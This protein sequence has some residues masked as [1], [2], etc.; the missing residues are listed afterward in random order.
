MKKIFFALIA[1]FYPVF[2]F[3]ADADFNDSTFETELEPGFETESSAEEN[4][5]S[6]PD[7]ENQFADELDSDIEPLKSKEKMR[8]DIPK[9]V[10]EIGFDTNVGISNN[11]FAV[12]DILKKEL[13]IDLRKIAAEID[14]KGLSFDMVLSSDFFM[15]LNLRNGV[16]VGVSSGLE[17]S[18]N[19]VISKEFF[20][21]LG[22]GNELNEKISVDGSVNSDVF[23]YAKTDVSFDIKSF[24]VNFGP[25]LFL[26]LLHLETTKFDSHF[27][28]KSDG[29]VDARVIAAYKINSCMPL[30]PLFDKDFKNFFKLNNFDCTMGFDLSS[31][32]EHQILNTL[33][34]RA[35]IRLPIVPGSM[36]NTVSSTL[37]MSYSADDIFDMIKNEGDKLNFDSGEKNYGTEKYWI[38]RPFRTGGEIAW[39]PFGK[40]IKFGALLG[41]GVKY[42]WTSEAKAYVEYKTSFDASLFNI[43]GVNFSSSYINE[44]FIHQVGF[45]LN[46]H[47]LE[48]DF[49][50]SAQGA[51]FKKSFQGSGFGAY[52]GIRIGW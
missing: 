7:F 42:P 3:A 32:I 29:S 1:L 52:T 10:F 31:S 41:I 25:A 38:S 6:E 40:Y 43:L 47:V 35:Y 27:V 15:N 20:E 17:T 13:E 28:N 23:A 2:I 8:I 19:G 11:Y 21:F 22:Y 33:A 18:G 50:A 37:E 14:Q 30:E 48:I 51:S 39:K 44:I 16:S 24:R 26:P 46:C 12:Y 45:M 4:S 5:D 49:G 36:N 34:G 9:R